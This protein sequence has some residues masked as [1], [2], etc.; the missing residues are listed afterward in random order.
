MH[1]NAASKRPSARN[2]ESHN[3]ERDV[4]EEGGF[5]AEALWELEGKDTMVTWESRASDGR[6]K[7]P[8]RRPCINI[9]HRPRD[10][11]PGILD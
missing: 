2:K 9:Y 1:Q 5:F 7:V 3:D 10:V 6:R 11:D 4:D 8:Q